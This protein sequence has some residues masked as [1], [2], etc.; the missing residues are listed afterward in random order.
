MDLPAQEAF[1]DVTADSMTGVEASDLTIT[2]MG[3]VVVR[4]LARQEADVTK[5]RLG[6]AVDITFTTTTIL[7]GSGY[8]SATTLAEGLE[9]EVMAAYADP[10]TAAAFKEEAE[11][12]GSTSIDSTTVVVFEEPALD[13]SSITEEVVRTSAPTVTPEKSGDND[14]GQTVILIAGVVVGVVLVTIAIISSVVYN[15]KKKNKIS[16]GADS[17]SPFK[18]VRVAPVG[19]KFDKV[20]IDM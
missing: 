16:T 12:L 17:P 1:L 18:V 5:R 6:S 14:D 7:E 11:A 15:N 9:A 2:G 4:R 8:S 19:H 3:T 10:V 13:S 20:G